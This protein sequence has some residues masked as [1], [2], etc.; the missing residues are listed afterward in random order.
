MLRGKAIPFPDAVAEE[1]GWVTQEGLPTTNFETKVMSVPNYNGRDSLVRNQRM[2]EMLHAAFTPET[3]PQKLA[4]KWQVPV[5]FVQVAEDIRLHANHA[6]KECR[7]SADTWDDQTWFDGFHTW[8][9]LQELAAGLNEM[10]DQQPEDAAKGAVCSYLSMYAATEYYGCDRQPE[11][12][13]DGQLVKKTE[14]FRQVLRPELGTVCRL[15]RDDLYGLLRNLGGYTSQI[16]PKKAEQIAKFLDTN[17]PSRQAPPPPTAAQQRKLD[18][19]KRV[20]DD[21]LLQG[22]QQLQQPGVSSPQGTT[23]SQWGKMKMIYPALTLNRT[24]QKVARLKYSMDTGVQ[25]RHL[26]RAFTDGRIFQRQTH[27]AGGT[28]LVDVSGSMALTIGQIEEIL[29]LAPGATVATY[30]GNGYEGELRV[31]A[32]GG[33]V[34]EAGE[35]RNSHMGINTIDGPALDWLL[36]QQHPRFWVSDTEVNG[37]AGH[38]DRAVLRQE[39]MQKVIRG[40]VIVCGKANEAVRMFRKLKT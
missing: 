24:L 14:A 34:A 17:L 22:L 28:V 40:R 12:V 6:Y 26:H 38:Y 4:Q 5:E 21:Q 18:A 8:E 23:G 32:K 33:K 11:V 15:L 19:K 20:D 35:L 13:L 31:V 36:R 30:T 16:S 27:M 29:Q 3:T 25:I 39:C 10:F 37:L 1:K 2:H 7:S 9:E